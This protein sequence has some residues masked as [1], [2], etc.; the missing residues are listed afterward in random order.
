MDGFNFFVQIFL[1]KPTNLEIFQKI[2][3]DIGLKILDSVITFDPLQKMSSSKQNLSDQP[4][5]R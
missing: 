3:K 5:Q 2:N 1:Q 4:F